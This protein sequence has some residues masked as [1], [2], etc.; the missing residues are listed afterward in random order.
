MNNKVSKS[1]TI[2]FQEQPKW[3]IVT[4]ISGNEDSV[5]KNLKGKIASYGY[6]DS[7]TDI[8]VVKEKVIT[9]ED[10]PADKAPSN[11][12]RNS[13]NIQWK[14]IEKNGKTVYQK[15]KTEDR[16]KF[17]GYIFI[18]MFMDDKIWF[19]IRNTQLVTGI[20]GSS[21]KNTKPIP[22]SDEEIEKI[23]NH[24][25]YNIEDINDSHPQV[26]KIYDDDNGSIV[27][28][29]IVYTTDLSIDDEVRVI[30][31]NTIGE[32]GVIIA[33]NNAK[34]LATVKMEIFNRTTTIEIPY[35]NLEKK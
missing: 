28:E 3:Y 32:E 30:G 33:L 24:N 10:Y 13:K 7:V 5:V 4:V 1:S 11:V 27:M 16:N 34:G 20:I 2:E 15:I 17:G 22:V 12:G 35:S 23:L 18:K 31:G 14:T 21:G 8:R 25:E 26:N 6:N 9:I 19:I 29:S